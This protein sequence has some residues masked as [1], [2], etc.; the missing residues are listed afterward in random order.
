MTS[1]R[2]AELKERFVD[3]RGTWTSDWED[4]L[5]LDPDF[6]EQ[7]VAMRDVPQRKCHLSPKEQEFI[8]IAVHA[9]ATTVYSPAV[10]E[11]IKMALSLGATGEEVM[12]VIGLTSLV[13]VHTITLGAPILLEIFAEEGLEAGLPSATNDARRE[14][15]KAAF[16]KARGFW[17]ETW[18]PILRLDPDFFEAYMNFSSLPNRRNVLEPKMRELIYTA[19]DAATTHLYGR[20]T[21]IH[22]RNAVKHGATPEEIMEMLELVS[23]VGMNGVVNGAPIVAQEL[24]AKGVKRKHTESATV[25]GNAKSAVNGDAKEAKANGAPANGV[26][27]NGVKRRRTRRVSK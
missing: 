22:M 20:G 26:K 19:F 23:F 4:L 12:E 14:E 10:R 2:H 24:T 17:T 15:V 13:G 5:T 16:I 11:H 3:G 6:F 21:K 1:S 18:N 8:Y 9:S 27:A 7:Y 25:N